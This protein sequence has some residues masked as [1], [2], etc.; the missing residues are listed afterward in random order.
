MAN[1]VTSPW[2]PAISCGRLNAAF[3]VATPSPEEALF[4]PG[5]VPA[6]G[7]QPIVNTAINAP[8]DDLHAMLAHY[9]FRFLSLLR[10]L[11][12]DT[13]L[14]GKETLVDEE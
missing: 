13:R 8:A 14:V 9:V 5:G 7:D 4:A 12:V 11:A 2:C 3:I 10:K 6:V 1:T